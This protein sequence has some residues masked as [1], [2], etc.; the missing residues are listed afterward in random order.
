MEDDTVQMPIP[1][2]LLL[3]AQSVAVTSRSYCREEKMASL[4]PGSQRDKVLG[5]PANHFL[6]TRRLT[7]LV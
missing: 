7:R 6:D 2:W 4:F 5:G 1:A 3:M